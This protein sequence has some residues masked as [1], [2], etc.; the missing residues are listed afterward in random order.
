MHIRTGQLSALDCGID[1][2]LGQICCKIC[3]LGADLT[4]LCYMLCGQAA[5]SGQVQPGHLYMD[6]GMEHLVCR[7]GIHKNIEFCGR[8]PVTEGNGAAHDAQLFDSLYDSRLSVD[9]AGNIGQG[10]G[11]DQG[12]I[13]GIHNGVDDEIYCVLVLRLCHRLRKHGTVQSGLTVKLGSSYK[14]H[15]HG[16]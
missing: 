8:C 12:Y 1:E 16:T 2:E 13:I 11:S 15:Y 5:L 9:R 10:T 14:R 7:F 6:A 3:C 4:K